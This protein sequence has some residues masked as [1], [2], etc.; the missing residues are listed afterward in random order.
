MH[1]RGN[2][3]KMESVYDKDNSSLPVKY[4]LPVGPDL[5]YLNELIGTTIRL[6]Y[7]NKINCI[8]CGR[9]TRQS[10]A[11][12]YCYPCFIS[13]PQTDACILRPEQC[14]AHLGISRDMEWSE[15]NCLRDHF[16]Y[17]A[18]SPGLKVGVTRESQVPVRWIDQ[19]A[20]EAI[21]LAV[22]P[23]RYTAG[24]IEV[25]LKKHMSDKTN[26]RHMLTGLRTSDV[27]LVTEKKRVSLLLNEE[28]QQYIIEDD[29]IYTFEYPVE[30]YP[31]K[32]KTLNF[33][34][35]SMVE[36]VLKGIKGQ[37]LILENGYVLNIRKFGGYLVDFYYQ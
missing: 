13:L 19:G 5:I 3:R 1:I 4:S 2:L 32:I 36:G 22:T 17:L 29:E 31:S 35:D 9:E 6:E 11:Q 16:V 24:T 14:Q 15:R 21:K 34:K 27:D 37:Y 7:L 18:L 33:D 28:M 25:E 30:E 8:H 20:R 12:G 10:F 26:W 23:N